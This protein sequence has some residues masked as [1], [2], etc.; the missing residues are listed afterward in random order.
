M[1]DKDNFSSRWARRKQAVQEEAER[2]AKAAEAEVVEV[3]EP[4][5]IEDVSVELLEESKGD[6]VASDIDENEL[7]GE[8]GEEGEEQEPH[9]A[10]GIDIEKL[11]YESDFTVF[12]QDKVPEAVRRMALRKLWRSNPILANIDGLNDYD[13]DF[14]DA[15][16]VFINSVGDVISGKRPQFWDDD[17]LAEKQAEAEKAAQEEADAAEE[18]EIEEASVEEADNT[19][20][21]DT[22][23]EDME[24]ADVED[25][26]DFDDLEFANNDIPPAKEQSP[27][28]D[29]I[30]TVEETE[31][32][33]DEEDDEESKESSEEETDDTTGEK[34]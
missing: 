16:A 26:D 29:A 10:E 7:L 23:I 22:D 31:A 15:T 6:L 17:Q 19:D 34:I 2:E 24:D 20:T 4:I 27:K 3:A 30:K 32:E 13:E 28:P 18:A 11:E 33:A 21:E 14:T 8:D 5:D 9:P 12:M 25:I 1:S